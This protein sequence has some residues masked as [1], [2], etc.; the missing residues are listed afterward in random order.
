MSTHVCDN[1]AYKVGRRP[2]LVF[3][4]QRHKYICRTCLAVV[5]SVRLTA[6]L[7]GSNQIMFWRLFFVPIIRVGLISEEP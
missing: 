7:S 6:T 1:C 2:S 4:V 5:E 3:T